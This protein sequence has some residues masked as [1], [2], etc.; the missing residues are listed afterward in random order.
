MAARGPDGAGSWSAGCVA[1][2]HRRLKIIDLSEQGSQPLVD[3]HVARAVA[4]NGCIY[5]HRELRAELEREGH[6][7]F[8]TS[9]TEVI[10]KAHA[11]W[12]DRCVERFMGMFSF[13]LVERETGRLLLARDRLGIKP[14]Y[15]AE[16]AGALRFGST[17]PGLLAGGG[18]DTSI[19]PV[20][21][22]HYLS[23]H[24][25]VPPP[26]TMLKGVRKLQPAT[27]LAIEPDGRRTE[28][29][30]WSARPQPAARAGDLGRARLAGRAARR[31]ADCGRPADGRR[32]P[33]G[34]A[35]LRRPGLEPHR[36]AAGG[37]RPAR[38]GD[39]LD[40]LRVGRRP[41][42][43]RVPR[44]PT[45]SRTSSRPSTTRSRSRRRAWSRRSTARSRR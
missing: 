13:A 10:A 14:L 15:L 11:T 31:A 30:Y 41:R 16:V 3:P 18:V 43:G 26:H 42:G 25:V 40:R 12:G 6:R 5:N 8:S 22:H 23:W 9:D 39:L 35:A 2:A 27:I 21:L 7:F 38:A 1:L 19:D 34:G 17:L 36:G 29:R 32:R 45:S 33:G 37:G 24:G 4:F 44:T 20:A 28:A